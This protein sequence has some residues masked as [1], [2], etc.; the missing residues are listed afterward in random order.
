MNWVM[1]DAWSGQ[2]LILKIPFIL[3]ICAQSEACEP[4]LSKIWA[5]GAGRVVSVGF[6]RL[7]YPFEGFRSPENIWFWLEIGHRGTENT[8]LKPEANFNI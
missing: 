4:D 8:E 7:F 2:N 5:A 3:F 1:R 6:R